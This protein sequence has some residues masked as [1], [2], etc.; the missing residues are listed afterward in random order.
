ML[1]M[2]AWS[3]FGMMCS[4]SVNLVSEVVFFFGVNEIIKMHICFRVWIDM[5]FLTKKQRFRLMVSTLIDTVDHAPPKACL[6]VFDQVRCFYFAILE[7]VGSFFGWFWYEFL[8]DPW[9]NIAFSVCPYI[10]FIDVIAMH[11]T[12]LRFISNFRECI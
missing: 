10:F 3:F 12:S 5:Y 8:L 4:S 7:F 1:Y 11:C 9:K 6:F 2:R